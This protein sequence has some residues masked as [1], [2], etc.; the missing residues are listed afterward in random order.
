MR[1]RDLFA[2]V[3]A[4]AIAWPMSGRAQESSKS[5]RL[6]IL[7]ASASEDA[8]KLSNEPFLS[9][10]AEEGFVQG[11][12]LIVETR[13]AEGKLDRLPQLA[14]EIISFKPDVIFAPSAPAAAALK[15]LTTTI[16]I[17]FCFVNEPVALGFVQSLSHPGGNLTGM[18]NF[19]VEITGKRV[20]LLSEIVPN[21]RRL[22]IWFDPEAM[23]GEVEVRAAEAAAARLGIE[24]R[25]FD[26]RNSA[27]YARAAAE[28]EEWR[29]QGVYLNSDPTAYA[30]RKQIIGLM[31][32]NKLPCMY[33][34]ADYVR[35][36][37]LICYAANFPDTARRSASY[38]AKIFRGARPAELPIEQPVRV[39]FSINVKTARAL[40]LTV[41]QSVLLRADTVIE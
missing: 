32:A 20:E 33:S 2:G 3:T 38:A 40:G 17:V 4:T 15:A 19:S 8:Q 30:N 9:G 41:P 34:I 14:A 36:G 10:L 37:G 26:E 22:A 31:E 5:F 27:D 7:Q 18:S 16:P 21:L 35:D 1:R 39:D 25:R 28:T 13:Y 24:V 12:N 11:R 29:A 6:G 23:N